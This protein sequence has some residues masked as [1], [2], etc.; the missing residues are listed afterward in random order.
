MWKTQQPEMEIILSALRLGKR[1]Q[2][3]ITVCLTFPR[4]IMLWLPLSLS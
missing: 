3:Y 4:G 2:R 1:R